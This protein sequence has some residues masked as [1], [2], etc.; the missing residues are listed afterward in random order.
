MGKQN[1]QSTNE[2]WGLQ[3][4][5]RQNTLLMLCTLNDT[6]RIRKVHTEQ[7][8]LISLVMGARVRILGILGLRMIMQSVEVIILI[9]EEGLITQMGLFSMNQRILVVLRSIWKSP[10]ERKGRRSNLFLQRN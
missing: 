10:T 3:Q 7:Q 4:W 2:Y 5:G 8:S 9:V 1:L 6:R